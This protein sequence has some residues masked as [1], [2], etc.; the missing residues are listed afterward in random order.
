MRGFSKPGRT[1]PLGANVGGCAVRI[2]RSR[3]SSERAEC[4]Q[5]LIFPIFRFDTQDCPIW[6]RVNCRGD[7][8]KNGQGGSIIS[9]ICLEVFSSNRQI[10][11]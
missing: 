9:A 7:I 5:D 3:R 2:P 4:H 11:Y 8:L 10:L 1:V 6:C